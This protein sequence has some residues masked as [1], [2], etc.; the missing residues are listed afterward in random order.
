M[1]GDREGGDGGS[2]GGAGDGGGGGGSSGSGGEGGGE[3]GEGGEGTGDGGRMGGGGGLGGRGGGGHG[4][5]G[6]GDGGNRKPT[7]NARSNPFGI[8]TA[9]SIAVP[10]NPLTHPT[11]CQ[12]RCDSSRSLIHNQPSAPSLEDG[13]HTPWLKVMLA[14][15]WATR[16]PEMALPVFFSKSSSVTSFS[17]CLP[18]GHLVRRSRRVQTAKL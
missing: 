13:T 8:T 11:D 9:H 14:D 3:G 17:S 12:L 2:G 16:S 4:G 18:Q 6:G 5:D 15:L 10:G 1:W 7:S